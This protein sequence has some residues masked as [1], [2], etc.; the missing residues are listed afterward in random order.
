[1]VVQHEQHVASRESARDDHLSEGFEFGV[2][3]DP[4]GFQSAYLEQIAKE[5]DTEWQQGQPRLSDFGTP[6][7]STLTGPMIDNGTLVFFADDKYLGIAYRV[8]MPFDALV[9]DYQPMPTGN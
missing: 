3:T 4:D 7:F 1:M 6:D 8:T 5:A 9:A 2:I